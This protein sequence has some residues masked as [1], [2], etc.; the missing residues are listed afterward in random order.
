MARENF[1]QLSPAAYAE[2]LNAEFNLV[3]GQE[4]STDILEEVM[5]SFGDI[6][7]KAD[8]DI[9][10]IEAGYLIGSR[11]RGKEIKPY[12]D[13]DVLMFTRTL[14]YKETIATWGDKLYTLYVYSFSDLEHG[15]KGPDASYWIR[16]LEEALPVHGTENAMSEITRSVKEAAAEYGGIQNEKSLPLTQVRRV[17]EYRRKALGQLFLA[18]TG[19]VPNDDV[20]RMK[21]ADAARKFGE[22]Y[23]L[24]QHFMQGICVE[25][26]CSSY[27]IAR[28]LSDE[29]RKALSV[30]MDSN[31]PELEAALNTLLKDVHSFC[32]KSAKTE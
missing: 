4:L 3:G 1:N 19:A 17:I 8:I 31:S 26:E 12:S 7:K 22:N 14:P 15:L 30:C 29:C 21:V 20:L 32:A 6:L 5:V 23:V 28:T 9:S 16:S 2:I 10:Q 13:V 11:S 18:A 24:L 25:S 27:D